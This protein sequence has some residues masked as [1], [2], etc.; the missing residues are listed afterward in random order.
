MQ[1]LVEKLR[2][3][4][5]EVVVDLQ[6]GWL[7]LTIPR[8]MRPFDFAPCVEPD[9]SLEDRLLT[10]T[11]ENIMRRGEIMPVPYMVG[12]TS[13]ESLFM[14]RELLVEPEIMNIFEKNPQFYAPLSFN[15]SEND[16]RV[17]EVANAIRNLYFEGN[18]PTAEKRLEWAQFQSDAQF[19]FPV[20]RTV[21]F[22]A[23]VTNQPIYYFKFSYDGSLN[24]LKRLLLLTDYPGILSRFS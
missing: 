5:A 7:D 6:S 16:P 22:H 17:H 21:Q 14:I 23:R 20:D 12:Y 15:L 11:P 9:D 4:P 1:E 3:V 19:L 2:D 18:P 13:I 24:M 10:D 8:G